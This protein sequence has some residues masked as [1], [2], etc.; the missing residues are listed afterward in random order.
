MKIPNQE[1]GIELLNRVIPY[2]NQMKDFDF[3][4]QGYIYILHLEKLKV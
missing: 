1:K 4:Y 3:S 2:P